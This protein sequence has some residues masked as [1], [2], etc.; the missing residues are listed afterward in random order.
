MFST[1]QGIIINRY[2]S[3]GANGENSTNIVVFFSTLCCVLFVVSVGEVIPAYM[4]CR[5]MWSG[6]EEKC[7]FIWH[8]WDFIWS[9]MSTF[10]IV[11]WVKKVL[12]DFLVLFIY[13]NPCSHTGNLATSP[14]INLESNVTHSP[15]GPTK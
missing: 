1:C 3:P 15:I 14:A 6:V 9:F 13:N 11:M 10:F 12:S 2:D 4:C 8:F 7:K 5:V